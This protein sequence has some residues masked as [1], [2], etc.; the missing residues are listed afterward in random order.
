MALRTAG[1]AHRFPSTTHRPWREPDTVIISLTLILTVV[2]ATT[3]HLPPKVPPLGVVNNS[4]LTVSLEV[5]PADE[6]GWMS[7]GTFAP[8]RTTVREVIDQGAQW[9]V[10]ARAGSHPG[11]EFAVTR[12]QMRDRKWTVVIPAAVV[13]SVRRN[14]AVPEP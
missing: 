1:T 14:G 10:R 5:R 13:E 2:I 12:S 6:S 11:P 4:D 7:L 3:L 8:G 9:L